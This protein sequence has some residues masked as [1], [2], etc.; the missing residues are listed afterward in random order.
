MYKLLESYIKWIT[1]FFLKDSQL[2]KHFNWKYESLNSILNQDSINNK[3]SILYV[4]NH[5]FINFT[6]IKVYYNSR[7]IKHFHFQGFN[8]YTTYL[9]LS[10]PYLLNGFKQSYT[11]INTISKNWGLFRISIFNLTKILFSFL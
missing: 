7:N 1:L 5:Y 11:L 8:N 9:E 4:Y 2:K 6:C 10:F 3:R